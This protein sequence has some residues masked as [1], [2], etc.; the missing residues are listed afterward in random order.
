[1]RYELDSP[2]SISAHDHVYDWVMNDK[3]V[4]TNAERQALTQAGISDP[5]G[6]G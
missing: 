6:G 3:S 1:M 4:L 2:E 5:F